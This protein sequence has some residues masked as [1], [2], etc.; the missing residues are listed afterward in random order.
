[1]MSDGDL[2]QEYERKFEKLPEDQKFSKL[3]SEAGLNL[4]EIGQYF[5]ALPSPK[6]PNTQSLC[7]EYTLP[8]DDERTCVKGWIQS[9]AK[10]GP[11][12]DIT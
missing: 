12:S 6:E 5:Y 9:N 2:L 10:F 11:V 8:R 7:R 4:V 3:C 1:M